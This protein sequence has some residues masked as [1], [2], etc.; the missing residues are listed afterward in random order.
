[1]QFKE[2]QKV[3]VFHASGKSEY[4]TFDVFLLLPYMTNRTQNVEIINSCYSKHEHTEWMVSKE[5]CSSH[6]DS[7]C[8]PLG[9]PVWTGA[10]TNVIQY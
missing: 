4:I 10:N 3:Q 8:L 6:F 2:N 1:M 5:H 7:L 9:Y